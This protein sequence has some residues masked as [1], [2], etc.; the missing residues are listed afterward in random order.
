VLYLNCCVGPGRP[1]AIEQRCSDP[2]TGS[3]SHGSSE[4]EFPCS[5]RRG[6]DEA[7]PQTR[8]DGRKLTPL[9]I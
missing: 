3:A 2:G 9:P 6:H 5:A 8:N 1:V 4:R 7:H